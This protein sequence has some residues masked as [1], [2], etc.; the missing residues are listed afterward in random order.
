MTLLEMMLVIAIIGLVASLVAPSYEIIKKKAQGVT[1]IANLRQIGISVINATADNGRFPMIETDPS[2]PVYGPEDNAL[3]LLETLA[4]YGL[5]EQN[6]R[7]PCDIAGPN[8]FAR[9]GSS[10]EWRPILDGENAINPKLYGRMGVFH[11]SLTRIRLVSDF[12]SVH[13]GRQN[14]LYA[15]GHTRGF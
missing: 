15:D 1:C 7:C 2:N 9:T 11:P 3:G 10:Y 14:L 12:G 8:H 6:L 13:N 5:I 4:P